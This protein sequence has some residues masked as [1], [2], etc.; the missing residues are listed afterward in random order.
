[1][2][3]KFVASKTTTNQDEP[4]RIRKTHGNSHISQL[5]DS[6][7]CFLQF[8]LKIHE[9]RGPSSNQRIDL[10]VF[11]LIWAGEYGVGVQLYFEF[12]SG[13]DAFRFQECAIGSINSHDI[14][15]LIGDK[16]INPSP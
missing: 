9:F 6:W 4:G 5:K 12:L 11:V 3:K 7:M 15:I 2:R 1:M 10:L 13:G 8:L 16:L 14:S